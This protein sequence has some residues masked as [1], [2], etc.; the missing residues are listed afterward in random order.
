MEGTQYLIVIVEDDDGMRRALERLLRISGYRTL[1]FDSAE[2]PGAT[3]ATVGV[4][5]L[6]LDVQLPGR[7]GPEFYAQLGAGR[8][9]AVFITSH[10]SPATRRAISRF[11]G[12]EL[13]CKPFPG[14]V[15]L[16]A[17]VRAMHRGP[18]P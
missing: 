16:D 2:A 4:A 13:I 12:S 3:N 9:P 15:L 5:C 8:P 11:G 6:V 17:I 18:P 1:A 10:D 7:S 14:K